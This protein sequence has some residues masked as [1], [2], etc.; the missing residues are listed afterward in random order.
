MQCP[1]N[2]VFNGKGVER[3]LNWENYGQFCVLRLLWEDTQTCLFLCAE[4]SSQGMYSIWSFGLPIG[5]ETG[6][7]GMGRRQFY[8][9]P[10]INFWSWRY[11][12][13]SKTGSRNRKK[14][15]ADMQ[16]KFETYL[17]KPEWSTCGSLMDGDENGHWGELKLGRAEGWSRY[18]GRADLGP[19]DHM[20]NHESHRLMI[21]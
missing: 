10:V 17:E 8:C 18:V 21:S 15:T 16:D 19:W 12:I 20:L 14:T 9:R 3:L 6:W 13:Y 1:K 11:Y 2:Q 4:S 7:L 5:R